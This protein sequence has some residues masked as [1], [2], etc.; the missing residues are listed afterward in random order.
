MCHWKGAGISVMPI[1]SSLGFNGQEILLLHNSKHINGGLEKSFFFMKNLGLGRL[2]QLPE[3]DDQ[4]FPTCSYLQE[5]S[6][7]RSCFRSSDGAL[8]QERSGDGG[9]VRLQQPQLPSAGG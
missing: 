9:G 4:C 3:T 2:P 1:V 7:R 5:G 6:W 8:F